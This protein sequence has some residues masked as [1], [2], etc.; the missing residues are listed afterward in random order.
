MLMHSP[1]EK[2]LW[3]HRVI[4]KYVIPLWVGHELSETPLK[5]AL[6]LQFFV[7]KFF[8]TSS[9]LL[10]C[11]HLHIYICLSMNKVL[12]SFI[13]FCLPNSGHKHTKEG[14]NKPPW[15][16]LVYSQ[17]FLQFIFT[18]ATLIYFGCIIYSSLCWVFCMMPLCALYIEI[19]ILVIIL[20]I[21]WLHLLRCT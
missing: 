1:I 20:L 10:L 21:S 8:S 4:R 2:M 7:F 18:L 6:L 9:D 14:S 17:V 13:L 11:N 12:M 3:S 15:L 19:I 16:N 5:P